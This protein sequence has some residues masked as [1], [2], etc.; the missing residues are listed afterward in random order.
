MEQTETLLVP[1]AAE[2][3][4]VNVDT[5]RRW[6]RNGTLRGA[7]PGGTKA[8]WRIPASEI[9]RVLRGQ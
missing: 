4:R 7:R 3:L 5:V 8:G 9:E 6:L 1:E 2:R